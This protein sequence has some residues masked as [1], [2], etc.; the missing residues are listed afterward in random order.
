MPIYDK[1]TKVLMEEWAREHLKPGQV[2]AKNLPVSWFKSNYPNIKSNTVEMHVEGMSVNNKNRKH[3]PNIK[4]GSGHDL[5]W[6]IAPGQ[7]RIWDNSTDQQPRYKADFETNEGSD[8]DFVEDEETDDEAKPGSPTFAREQDLQYYLVKNL[9]MLEPGLTLYEEEGFSGVEYDAGG[10]RIDI[11]AVDKSGGFVVIELKVAKGHEK[12]IGQILRYIGWVEQN[13]SNG[14]E[15]RG[16]IVAGNIS[17]DLILAT[18]KIPSV[19]LFEYEIQFSVK[20]VLL[21]SAQS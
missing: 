15:A 1:P 6:K 7:F 19:K 12:V 20:P 5:F 2:F 14:R 9:H 13:L 8:V 18:K 10:R 21:N 16:I 3:Y 4:P 11:L 17:Q